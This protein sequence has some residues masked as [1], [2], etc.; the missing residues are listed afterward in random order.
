M[1]KL[2]PLKQHQRSEKLIKAILHFHTHTVHVCDAFSLFIFKKDRPI[3]DMDALSHRS[4]GL[5]AKKQNR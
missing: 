3:I 5:S 4:K 2:L 1:K